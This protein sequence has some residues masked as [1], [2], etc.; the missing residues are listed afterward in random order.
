MQYDS[1]INL[2]TRIN[3]LLVE[4]DI[5]IFIDYSVEY[6]LAHLKYDE[7]HGIRPEEF[8]NEDI[9]VKWIK[10]WHK[11]YQHFMDNLPEH[12]RQRVMICSHPDEIDTFSDTVIHKAMLLRR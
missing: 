4:P 2:W 9:K 12:L 7:I 10:G 11:E 5:I 8:P 1:Y 3:E 6:S